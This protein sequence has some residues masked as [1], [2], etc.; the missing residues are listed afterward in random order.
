LDRKDVRHQA[1]GAARMWSQ[2]DLAIEPYL[3][4]IRRRAVAVAAFLLVLIAG[5]ASRLVHIQYLS[6]EEFAESAIRQHGHFERLIARPGDVLDVHGRPMATSV[7]SASVF[8]DPKAVQ[9]EKRQDLAASLA[10]A[11]DIDAQSLLDRLEKHSNR[12]FLWV[13]RRVT[14][15]DVRAVRDLKWPTAW[16]GLQGELRRCYPQGALASHVLGVRDIDGKARDGVERVFNPVLDGKPGRRI[17]ARDARGKTLAIAEHLTCLPEPGSSVV[18]TLDSVVQVFVEEALDR[19]MSQWKPT[20]ATAIV[21]DPQTGEIV[22]LAN[23]PTFN[24]EDSASA[25][26]DAWVNRAISDTY[27]PGSTFKPFIVASALDWQVV[28]PE[29][30][31]DCHNGSYRM[32]PRLLHSHHPN[33]VLAVPEVVVKSDNIG[34]AIIG[35]RMTN[36]GLYRAV[37]SFGFGRPTGIELPGESS[38]AVRPLRQ[39][40]PFY[41]TGSVPMGQELSVTPLQLIT[42]FSAL[43]NGGEL[44]RP[45]IIRAIVGPDGKTV[46]VFDKPQVVGKP[47]RSE[48]ASY[49]VES[50]LTGVVE[51]GTGKKAQLA[52]YSV[53]GKTGTA[54]K[55]SPNGGY[56][57]HRYISS[58]MAGAPAPDPRI[59]VLVVLDDPRNCPDPFGGKVA[60]PAVAEILRRSLTYLNVPPDRDEQDVVSSGRDGFRFTD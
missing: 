39:W 41:S 29:D 49:M 14:D 12:R 54:Q 15:D 9:P 16:V 57:H 36:P 5:L 55:Q 51:R 33:G 26:S 59:V 58:F 47:V 24:P 53:F 1:K 22:A 38:G 60:A 23:R 52:G 56:M 27:E 48:T 18:L 20:S 43:A 3:A 4:S 32:G 30:Q 25:S 28:A 46:Q 42:A 34:M 8:V 19:V 44:L 35:E 10:V 13:K 7:E 6:R 40:T 21:M 2:S 37:Q 50:V 45:R 11:L 17:T 31:I